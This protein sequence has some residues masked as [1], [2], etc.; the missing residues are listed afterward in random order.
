MTASQRRF[1]PLWLG[2][3]GLLGIAA[4]TAVPLAVDPAGSRQPAAMT[5]IANTEL[6]APARAVAVEERAPAPE[7]EPVA[8]ALAPSPAPPAPAPPAPPTVAERCQAARA[9]V[10]A[11]GLALPAR[12]EY[13]C[14][15]TQFAH[16]GTACYDWGPCAGGGFIAINMDMLAGTDQAYLQH[17]VAHEVC[18]IYDFQRTGRTSEPGADACAAAWGF[19]A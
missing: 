5:G 10:A 1:R 2:I 7:P 6:D 4:T 8:Q 16:H 14:P 3:A 17:V 19:P 15:S 12:I 13:R 9:T 11:A 18:H